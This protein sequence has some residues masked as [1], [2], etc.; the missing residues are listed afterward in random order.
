MPAD[1]LLGDIGKGHKVAFNVL[2]FGRFKL[3][4]MCV[5]GATVAIAESARYA[6]VATAVRSA[7][8]GVRGDQAQAR[9]D[10]GPELRGREPAV[11]HGG[12]DRCSQ[13]A[14]TH[15]RGGTVGAGGNG[16]VRD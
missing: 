12:A 7:D 15:E 3:G 6:A 10:D 2:N 11:P 8:R 16:G 9:G 5:G 1:N 14:Q 4:G 13:I